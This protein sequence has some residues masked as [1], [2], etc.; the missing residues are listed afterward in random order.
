MIDNAAVVIKAIEDVLAGVRAG[1]TTL[2]GD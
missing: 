2:T 1:R